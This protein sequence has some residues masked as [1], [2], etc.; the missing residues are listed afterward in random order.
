MSQNI[1]DIISDVARQFGLNKLKQKQKDAIMVFVQG[2][3][4]FVSLPTGYGKSIIYT[5]LPFIFDSINCI[6][7][8]VYLAYT[9]CSGRLVVCISPLIS[10]MMDQRAKLTAH[11]LK[12][13]YVGTAQEDPEA[14]Q[15]V[16][17]DDIQ[18]LFISPE[19]ILNN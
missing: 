1:E 18:L 8:Y 13:E 3:D 5:A 16:L 15:Q 9:N 4:V 10:I 7:S 11:G 17:T 2:Q 14:V 19:S 12:A 6:F